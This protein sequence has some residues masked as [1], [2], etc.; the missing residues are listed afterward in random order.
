[1]FGDVRSGKLVVVSV[2]LADMVVRISPAGDSA[3]ASYQIDVRNRHS[4]GKV[5]DEHAFESDVWFKRAG[6]WKIVHAQYSLATPA[7]E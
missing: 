5:T 7:P 2:K 6:V 4:N 1:M 3:I